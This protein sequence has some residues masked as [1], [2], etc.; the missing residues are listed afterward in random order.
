MTLGL[1]ADKI[2]NM[3]I[4]EIKDPTTRSQICEV[5]LRALP[6]WF[7]IEDATR[8]YIAS[9]ARLQTIAAFDGSGQLLGFLSLE[10][11]FGVNAEI[12]VM[13]VLPVL[14]RQGVGR[15]LVEAAIESSRARLA[16]F[17]SVKTLSPSREDAAYGK[18]RQ[19]YEAIGFLKFEEFPNFWRPG[20]PCL[21]LVLTL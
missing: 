4:L 21:E 10:Y 8:Q 16:K 7:G 18:T 1:V 13:G 17:L 9:V 20:N 3:T 2:E 14:H 15:A 6:N 5:I 12:H 11:H 19:F